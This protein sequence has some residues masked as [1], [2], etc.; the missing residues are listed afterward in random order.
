MP[1][2]RTTSL[3]DATP[4]VV[5]ATPINVPAA[6]APAADARLVEPLASV[7]VKYRTAPAHEPMRSGG[8]RTVLSSHVSAALIVKL[9]GKVRLIA[10]LL[11]APLYG[12]AR[13]ALIRN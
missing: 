13:C 2:T 8:T 9:N 7:I 10:V 1:V 5:P 12:P 3:V 11:I 6:H 4:F